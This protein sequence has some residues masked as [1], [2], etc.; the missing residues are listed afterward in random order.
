MKKINVAGMS[1]L[2]GG[3]C[4]FAY[5]EYDIRNSSKTGPCRAYRDFGFQPDPSPF[6]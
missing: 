2:I 1:S 3:I 4:M 6:S 5:H